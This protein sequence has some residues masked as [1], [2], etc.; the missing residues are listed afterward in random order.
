MYREGTFWGAFL[1]YPDCLLKLYTNEWL[2]SFSSDYLFLQPGTNSLAL[3]YAKVKVEI[4]YYL[5]NSYVKLDF[6]EIVFARR[7]TNDIR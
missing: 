6:T 7:E 3:E 5:I 1:F 2:S 4:S